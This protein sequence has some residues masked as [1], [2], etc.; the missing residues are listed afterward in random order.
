MLEILDI[1]GMSKQDIPL[2]KYDGKERMPSKN[3]NQY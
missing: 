3:K 1:F 2:I